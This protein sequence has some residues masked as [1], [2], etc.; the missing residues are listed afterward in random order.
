MMWNR[1]EGKRVVVGAALLLFLTLFAAGCGDEDESTSTTAPDVQAAVCR[2]LAN[3]DADCD[4]VPNF[5]DQ[6]SGANDWDFDSDSDTVADPLDRYAGD[7]YGDDDGDGYANRFDLFPQDQTQTVPAIAASNA[8]QQVDAERQRLEEEARRL[9]NDN[10]ARQAILDYEERHSQD[11]D[12]DGVIDLYDTQLTLDYDAD[13]DGDG[14]SNGHDRFPI[15][16]S[17]Y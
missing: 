9:Q 16:D 3:V 10:L 4:R 15:D 7:D 13:E 2:I 12:S 1:R 17:G 8:Q 11:T 6:H 5:T 14:Y